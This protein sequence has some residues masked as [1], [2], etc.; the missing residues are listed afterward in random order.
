MQ[1]RKP[2][3]PHRKWKDAARQRLLDKTFAP[4]AN[5]L[6]ELG[7]DPE[8]EREIEKDFERWFGRKKPVKD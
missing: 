5:A 3:Q 2:G 6:C 8:A 4:L 1:P 7:N